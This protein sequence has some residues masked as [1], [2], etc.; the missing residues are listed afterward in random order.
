MES[1]NDSDGRPGS[2]DAKTS[3]VPGVNRCL[4]AFQILS[5]SANANKA[6]NQSPLRAAIVE[7]NGRF[8][9]W[10]GNIGAHKIGKSSLDSRLKESPY[11]KTRVLSLLDDL[12]SL[13]TEGER[14]FMLHTIK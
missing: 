5:R 13:L 1:M 6:P 9:V 3:S 14:G 2:L 11:I 8:R 4:K 12:S 10:S 7:C